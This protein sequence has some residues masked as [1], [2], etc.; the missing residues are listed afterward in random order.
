MEKLSA[1]IY[2]LA[3]PCDTWDPQPVVKAVPLAVQVQS[4]KHWTT[5]KVPSYML[6]KLP[7]IP[8][9][10]IMGQADMTFVLFVL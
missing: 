3:V 10:N 7:E 1:F 8:W 2:L 6:L 4:P 9:P 5:R